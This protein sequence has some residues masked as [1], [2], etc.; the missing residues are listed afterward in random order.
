MQCCGRIPPFQ[1]SHGSMDL[2]NVGTQPR[3]YTAS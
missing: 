3:H 2:W 1:R